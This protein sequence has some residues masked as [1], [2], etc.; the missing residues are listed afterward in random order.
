M[1][2]ASQAFV[3]VVDAKMDKLMKDFV[4]NAAYFEQHAPWDDKYKLGKPYPPLARAVEALIET[5][6]FEV[7]TIGENLP[8]ETEIHDNYGSKSFI[9]TGSTRALNHATGDAVTR[10]FAYSP[11]E[12]ERAIKYR[13]LADDLITT[14]H[15]IIGHG[16]GK[17]NPRL[18]REPAYYIKEYYSTLEETRADLMALWNLFDP[19]LI[20]MG[21][22]PN[23]EAAKAVYDREARAALVQ[24]REVPTGD[25]IEEDHRR[26]TQLIINYVRDKTGAIEPVEREGKTYLVVKDYDKMRQGVGMLL[27]ELMRIKAEGDYDSAKA[28]VTRYGIHFNKAWRDQVL[29]R[30]KKLDLPIYWAGINPDLKPIFGANGKMRDVQVLYPRDIVKQ[31]LRYVEIAGK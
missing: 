25:T 24:L 3:T 17:M 16:S 29:E 26:G 30:Y 23:L 13:G 2:G 15:E 8:N 6:D 10:E 27:A 19:K 4:A 5:G 7:N 18:T 22:V 12:I 31:Q 11:E 14:M 9:F 28:L 1:K 21:A 20:E